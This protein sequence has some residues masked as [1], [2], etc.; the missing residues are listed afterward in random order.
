MAAESQLVMLRHLHFHHSTH[1]R[2]IALQLSLRQLL[3][4]LVLLL[5]VPLL[6]GRWIGVMEHHL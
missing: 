4:L 1:C 6:L 3:A 2:F 5:V